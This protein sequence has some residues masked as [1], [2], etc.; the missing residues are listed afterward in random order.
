[1][2]KRIAGVVLAISLAGLA[3]CTSPALKREN[4][5]LK[6]RVRTLENKQAALID[7]N[8][9]LKAH[10]DQIQAQLAQAK[11][12]SDKLTRLVGDLRSEQEKMLQQRRELEKLVQG[13]SGITVQPRSEGNFIVMESKILFAS[14]K[15]D[16]NDEAKTTLD[17]VAGYLLEHPDLQIRVDGHTDGVPI[18]YSGWQDNYQL[19]A[20]RAHSVMRYLVEKGVDP[21]RMYITGF[22]PNRPLVEPEEPTAP[23]DEN[24]RVEILLVPEGMRSISEILKGF[25]Q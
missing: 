7:E 12:E 24:R 13:L 4:L 20:M 22:G 10:A 18:R 14:G 1:M 19:A 16:L 5:A 2:L 11:K 25:G 6:E 3:G 15:A 8:E 21:A 9:A 23:V 17:R